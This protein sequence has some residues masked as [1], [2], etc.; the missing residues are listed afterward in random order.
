MTKLQATGLTALMLLAA[1]A[2]GMAGAKMWVGSPAFAMGE[3]GANVTTARTLK[4][5]NEDGKDA[6]VMSVDKYGDS[7]IVMYD[8]DGAVSWSQRGFQIMLDEQFEEGI[9]VVNSESGLRYQILTAGDGVAAKST[10]TVTVHYRGWLLNGTEFDSSY[11]RNKPATFPLNG[12]IK[13]WTEGVAGMLPGEKRRLVIPPDLGYGDGGS[14]PIPP[15]SWLVFDV[16]LV[17]VGK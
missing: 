11:K 7:S 15:S 13:G 14:G 16:E 2:G 9:D 5:L 8:K 4:I 1:F 12:V 10:D 3:E 6:I 17:K